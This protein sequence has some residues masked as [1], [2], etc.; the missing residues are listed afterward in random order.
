MKIHQFES[1]LWLPYPPQKVFPFFS[2]ASNLDVITPPWLHFQIVTRPPIRMQKGTLIDYKLR[3]HGIP[4]KWRT[5]I[6]EWDPPFRFV[7]HQIKGPYRSWVHTHL[8]QEQDGGTRMED[9]VEYSI[10]LPFLDSLANWIFIEPDLDK[11]FNYRK[12]KIAQN[13]GVQFISSLKKK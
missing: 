3:L 9:L 4:I 8:F 12:E 1:A 11:I 13:Y 10:P 5:E 7:D 2:D 6:I